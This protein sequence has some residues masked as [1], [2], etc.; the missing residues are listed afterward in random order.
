MNKIC[1]NIGSGQRKFYTNGNY[2]WIN[3]DI[4]PKW[5]PDIVSTGENIPAAPLSA[6]YVVLHH[7]LE[8]YGCGESK[9]LLLECARILK[10]GGSLIVSV[11]DLY[12]LST[13]WIH[14]RLSTQ[15]FMTNVYGAYMDDEA[16]R[17]KWG[18][19]KFS[20]N[21]YL[22]NTLPN[23]V[24]TPFNYRV[25]PGADIAKDFWICTLEARV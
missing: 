14:G 10:P 5:Q 21:Q 17:H 3:V 11:P 19:D 9:A 4:N 18:F 22:K 25:I 6:D 23:A 12:E 15:V 2:T 13:A 20:L 24:V 8:H 16:D 1:Y 7:V